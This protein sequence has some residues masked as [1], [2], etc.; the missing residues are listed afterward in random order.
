MPRHHIAGPGHKYTAGDEA[1][2]AIRFLPG[3]WG[4]VIIEIAL[5]IVLAVIILRNLE[6]IIGLG[7][8]AVIGL[9]VLVI[10]GA[11]IYGVFQLPEV[12]RYLIGIFVVLGIAVLLDSMTNMKYK[13]PEPLPTTAEE[14]PVGEKKAHGARESRG[15]SPRWYSDDRFH[16][17]KSDG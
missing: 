4:S 2:Q 16:G 10:V 12:A 11:A 17:A 6:L 5:G 8:F 9:I 7:I 1:H 3:R 15:S 13:K 14:Q